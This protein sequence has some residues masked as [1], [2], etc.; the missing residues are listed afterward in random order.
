MSSLKPGLYSLFTPP[1]KTRS[2]STLFGVGVRMRLKTFSFLSS[3]VHLIYLFIVYIHLYNYGDRE[4]SRGLQARQVLFHRATSA[5]PLFCLLS[6]TIP[7]V[8]PLD[9]LA[10]LEVIK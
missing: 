5:A 6:N 10:L 7:Y 2:C 9:S 1:K 4:Q 8:L 3:A